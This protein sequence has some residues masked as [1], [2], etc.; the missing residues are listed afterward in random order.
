M[1]DDLVY[2][3][4]TTT[5]YHESFETYQ[6]YIDTYHEFDAHYGFNARIDGGWMFFEFSTDYQTWRNQK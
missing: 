3:P 1:P 2:W 6:E 5:L 4:Q